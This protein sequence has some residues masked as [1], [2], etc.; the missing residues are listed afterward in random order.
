MH[1]RILLLSLLVAAP[2]AA[3]PGPPGSS[4][5]YIDDEKFMQSIDKAMHRL[6]K[7]HKVARG[8]E[9]LSQ[10][11]RKSCDIAPA[12]PSAPVLT[13]EEIYTGCSGAVV[14]I[15]SA[16]KEEETKVW[17]TGEPATAWVLTPDGVLVT[18]FHVFAEAE[19]E[20][21][22]GIMTRDGAFYP[23]TEILAADRLN[24][25]AVFK[26]A[27]KN[28][29]PLALAGDE[30]V[31]K[32]V[33][34]ISHPD[35]QFYTFTQGQISRY[36]VQYDEA[37]APGI[38]YMSIT[39]DF[40]RGSSGGP[41]LNEHGAVA[42]MVCSTRTTYYGE[43]GKDKDDDVQMVVKYCIPAESIRALLKK[44]PGLPPVTKDKTET[45][46]PAEAAPAEEVKP[47]IPVAPESPAPD[48][49]PPRA[50]PVPE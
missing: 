38:K 34:V 21:F 28:L 46:K 14:A 3:D 7:D 15:T 22:F 6:V 27:A 24:D 35:R 41:V 31:G 2:L 29:Q 12:P 10:L 17:E 36:T 44:T 26:V 8:K 1:P 37:G 47:A 49:V 43:K 45:P 25:I 30:P 33:C 11:N 19:K 42:G 32:R 4:A 5:L 18:N 48:E 9:L 16:W 50:L 40:A 23:V 20:E 39:A 13:P